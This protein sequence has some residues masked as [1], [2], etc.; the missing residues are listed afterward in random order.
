MGSAMAKAGDKMAHA[1]HVTSQC[2]QC[3]TQ[4]VVTLAQLQ[5]RKGFVRCV[6]CAHIFDAY[7][8]IVATADAAIVPATVA[9]AAP[10]TPSHTP[11]PDVIR[12]RHTPAPD[13][14][15]QR[16]TITPITPITANADA[17][18][19][20]FSIS[21]PQVEPSDTLESAWRL[22]E[23]ARATSRRPTSSHGAQAAPIAP[24]LPN[25][26]TALA[27]FLQGP[28]RRPRAAWFWGT[29]C[30]LALLGALAQAGLV[31]RLQLASQFPQL[32]PA[33]ERLCQV[34]ACQLAYP[35]QLD[36]IFILSSSLRMQ[37]GNAPPHQHLILHATLRNQAERAQQWPSLRL[38]LTDLSGAVVIRKH[39][40]AKDYLPAALAHAPFAATS[41]FAIALPLRIEGVSVN[42]YQITPFFP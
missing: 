2:P 25:D 19:P 22:D 20:Q 31:Y 33:L 36:Q 34:W 1:R 10:Q 26:A 38:D 40:S 21:T 23:A 24:T 17:A 12:Q 16:H 4:F 13:V 11:A 29:L 7:A 28:V 9:P 15:R 35:R 8:T 30:V 3:S 5:L 41:E 42:G 27:E 32:R 37:P 6:H 14:I 39:L 18:E